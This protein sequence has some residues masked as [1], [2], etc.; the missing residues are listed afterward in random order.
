MLAGLLLEPSHRGAIAS[1][2]PALLYGGLAL[3]ALLCWLYYGRDTIRC[4]RCCEQPRALRA[5]GELRHASI[6]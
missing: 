5:L 6:L 3:L 2:T 1:A 4:Q